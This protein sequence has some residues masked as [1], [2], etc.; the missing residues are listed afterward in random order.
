MCAAAITFAACTNELEENTLPTDALVLTVGDY[1]AF[2]EGANTRAVGTFDPGKTA[3]ANGDKVLVSVSSNGST[4]QY[5][6]LTYESGNWT[7]SQTLTRPTGNYTV[8]AWYAPAYEWGTNNTLTQISGGQ[9]GT[10]EFLTTTSTTSSI[11]FS[12]STR[13]YSRL[14]FVSS[15][16]TALTVTLSNFTPAGGN[17]TSNYSTTLTTD[18][19]GNAYL[20][21]S[22]GASTTLTVSANYLNSNITKTLTVSTASKSYAVDTPEYISSIPTT[23]INSSS[24][25]TGYYKLTQNIT[26]TEKWTPIGNATTDNASGRFVGTFDGDGHTITGLSASNA[27]SDFGL[28]RLI[29]SNG[30]VRNLNL[31]NCNI[32]GTDSYYGGIVGTNYGTVENCHVSGSITGDEYVGGI[33]GSLQLGSSII[34]CSNS[35]TVSGSNLIGGICGRSNRGI[36]IACRNEGTVSGSTNCGG[37]IG[38]LNQSTDQLIA[39]C[40]TCSTTNNEAIAGYVF[41]SGVLSCYFTSGISSYG[42]Q[43]TGGWTSAI[44][45]MNVAIDTYNSTAAIKCN[46]KYELGANNLPTLIATE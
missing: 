17:A 6:T 10:D 38:R 39:S 36:V 35:A 1:P 2:S 26:L 33:A 16:S 46:Y 19:K 43:V 24:D 9:A 7:P 11:D 3:W 42:T 30:V 14:R 8:N 27:A 28:F 21:G 40:N 5:A 23:W 32:S 44:E 13:N 4:T 25:I 41:G 31:E 34:A 20:Y 29:G 12:N 15:T 37:L 45:D 22:W 18:S